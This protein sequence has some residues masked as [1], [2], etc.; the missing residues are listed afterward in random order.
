MIQKYFPPSQYTPNLYTK[1]KEFMIIQTNENYIGYYFETLSGKYYTGKDPNSPPTQEL[2]RLTTPNSQPPN[3]A[4]LELVL[5][6]DDFKPFMVQDEETFIK[7]NSDYTLFTSYI[8]SPSGYIYPPRY[9]FTIPTKEDYDLGFYK[10]YFLK[11]NT[12]VLYGEIENEE[13]K[14]FQNS[15]K[16]IQVEL[17]SSTSVIWVLKGEKEEVYET[18]KNRVNLIETRGTTQILNQDPWYGFINYFN[19]DFTKYHK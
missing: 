7:N 4:V 17:Y 12:E 5:D 1:G 16:S 9:S 6:W 18:N 13:Y 15:D 2:F 14:K 11:K 3:D 19:G 10:R 8:S